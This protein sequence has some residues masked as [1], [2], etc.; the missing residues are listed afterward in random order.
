MVVKFT[1]YE[2]KSLNLPIEEYHSVKDHYKLNLDETGG[3]GSEGTEKLIVDTIRKKQENKREE[4]KDLVTID[5]VGIAAG[6]IGPLILLASGNKLDSKAIKNLY[7][8]GHPPVST[9]IM[10]PSDYLD[11][12][13]WIHRVTIIFKGIHTISV[14]CDYPDLWVMLSLNVYYS[15]TN[16]DESL[17]LFSE[18]KIFVVKE[19]GDTS[20][21]D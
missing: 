5:R 6:N 18:Y 14:I 8:K 16:M 7:R 1:W 4:N 19:E 11:N 20:H 21:I 17:K 3:I 15:H 9:L 2:L 12:V 10:T 13:S